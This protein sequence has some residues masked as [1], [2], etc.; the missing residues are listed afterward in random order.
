MNKRR[1]RETLILSQ[2]ITSVKYIF[3]EPNSKTHLKMTQASVS[4][5]VHIQTPNC[6]HL[7]PECKHGGL[8]E[9]LYQFFILNANILL[10]PST[11]K[12]DDGN[13]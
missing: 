9:Q 6:F 11:D 1:L 7:H 10:I 12:F 8:P 3:L 5:S 2:G 4:I 13:C